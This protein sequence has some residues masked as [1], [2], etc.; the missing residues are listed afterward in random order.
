MSNR[1]TFSRV[2]VA[3]VPIVPSVDSPPI[4]ERD[5]EDELPPVYQFPIVRT[6]STKFFD[7]GRHQPLPFPDSDD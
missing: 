2:P 4:V 7:A 1:S 6:V 5:A 3:V